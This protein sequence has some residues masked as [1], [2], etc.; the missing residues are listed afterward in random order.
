MSKGRHASEMLVLIHAAEP[1]RT[2]RSGRYR[3]SDLAFGD[4]E[5]HA[6]DD[7]LRQRRLDVLANA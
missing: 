1:T 7:E 5:V 3:P 4:Q 2:V 6:M